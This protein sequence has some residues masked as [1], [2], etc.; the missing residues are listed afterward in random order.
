M[1]AEARQAFADAEEAARRCADEARERAAEVLAE[2]HARVEGIEQETGRVLR[3]HAGRRQDVQTQMDHVCASLS[4]LTG[5]A[6]E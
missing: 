3:E 6:V 2:A 5:R 4:A 1:L